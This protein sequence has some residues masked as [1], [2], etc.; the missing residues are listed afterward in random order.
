MSRRQLYTFFLEW[1]AVILQP[2]LKRH[3]FKKRTRGPGDLSRV[4]NQPDP[5]RISSYAF[6]FPHF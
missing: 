2:L 5:M 1:A 3:I 4:R 6:S